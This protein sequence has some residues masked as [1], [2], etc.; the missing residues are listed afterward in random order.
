MLLCRHGCR[1]GAPAHR[2]S[3]AP[4]PAPPQSS[5]H[6]HP[7]R[8]DAAC[9]CCRARICPSAGRADAPRHD[10]VRHSAGHHARHPTDRHPAIRHNTHSFRHRARR[11]RPH[12]TNHNPHP[13]NRAVLV[14]G[15]MLK[16][17]C[18]S[19]RNTMLLS[20]SHVF[21][22]L[23]QSGF[24][25][26]HTPEPDSAAACFFFDQLA[27]TGSVATTDIES[28]PCSGSRPTM[29]TDAASRSAPS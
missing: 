3:A 2:P 25:A 19:S 10:D 16:T 18:A 8:T 28:A 5:R 29:A 17:I 23:S 20:A 1:P 24:P 22:R 15:S 12:L 13:D 4:R 14:S 11:S 6:R 9:V 7:S 26:R 27:G 21:S